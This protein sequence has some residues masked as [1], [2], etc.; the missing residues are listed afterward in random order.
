MPQRA[1]EVETHGSGTTSTAQ[2]EKSGERVS[3]AREYAGGGWRVRLLLSVET[4]E[5]RLATLK[6]ARGANEVPR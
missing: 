2:D 6:Q 3:I 1:T 4:L 5:S